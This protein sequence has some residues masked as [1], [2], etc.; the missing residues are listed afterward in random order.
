MAT[1]WPSVDVLMFRFCE[2]PVAA[3]AVRVQALGSPESAGD[4]PFTRA[5][6]VFVLL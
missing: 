2:K 6:V 3:C 1:F 4:K 5:S